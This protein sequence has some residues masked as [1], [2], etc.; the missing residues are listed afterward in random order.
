MHLSISNNNHL[1]TPIEN[2][3]ESK[4]ETSKHKDQRIIT[5]AARIKMMIELRIND[6]LMFFIY[7]VYNVFYYNCQY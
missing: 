7:K 2:S 1:T 3:K 5:Q 4:E 6:I